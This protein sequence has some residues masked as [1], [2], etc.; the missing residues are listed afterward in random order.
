MGPEFEDGVGAVFANDGMGGVKD[1]L[2]RT[3]V[4]FQVDG[5]EVGKVFFK[6]HEVLIVGAAEGINTLGGVTDGG[7][8]VVAEGEEADDFVLGGIGILPF[9]YEE[10][11]VVVLVVV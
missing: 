4:L 11:A 3:V 7:E 8:L 6:A 5:G 1:G 10:M 2:R 9:V